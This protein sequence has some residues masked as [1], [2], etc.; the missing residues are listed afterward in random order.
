MMKRRRFV[1]ASLPALAG[2]ALAGC[3]G[4]EGG[5][6]A[7]EHVPVGALGPVAAG[8]VVF[9]SAADWSAFWRSHPAFFNP[10]ADAPDVDFARYAV[11]GV[12]A[13]PK[14]RCRTLEIHRGVVG[15]GGVDLFYRIVTFGQNTPSSCIGAD[16]FVA[17]LADAVL[18]PA[19]AQS[20]R[21]F[22]TS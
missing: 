4:S 11:A 1:I 18:I 2:A 21:F 5:D 17:N 6:L 14:P 8:T 7:L 3:G 19:D 15:P 10:A 13:G 16:P 12:F 20:V 9:R 22:E